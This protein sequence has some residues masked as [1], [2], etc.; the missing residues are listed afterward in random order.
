MP[1]ND[2]KSRRE[3][4]IK[5]RSSSPKKSKSSVDAQKSSKDKVVEGSRSTTP[6]KKDKDRDELSS[7][8]KSAKKDKERD[9]ED[10]EL[11]GGDKKSARRKEA[12]AAAALDKKKKSKKGE[13]GLGDSDSGVEMSSSK[14]DKSAKKSSDLDKRQENGKDR[15]RTKGK[16]E[17]S[18]TKSLKKAEALSAKVESGKKSSSRADLLSSTSNR[19]RSNSSSS[20]RGQKSG[21]PVRHLSFGQIYGKGDEDEVGP[22]ESPLR[23]SVLPRESS[24]RERMASLGEALGSCTKCL[25]L[26][27]GTGLTAW[28]IRR[29]FV[30]FRILVCIAYFVLG[31][32]YYHAKE[33]W[34]KTEAV[35]FITVATTTVGYGDFHPTTDTTRLFTTIYVV[36]GLVVVLAAANDVI[37]YFVVKKFQSKVLSAIDWIVRT[38]YVKCLKK[39]VKGSSL[40]SKAWFK[41]V[42]SLSCVVGLVFFG[43]TFFSSNED[44]TIIQALYWTVITML[45][46]GFGDMDVEKDSTRVFSTWFIWLCV[47][48]YVMAITNIFDTFEELKSEALRLEILKQHA[49][50]IVDVLDEE[51]RKR[52]DT[53]DKSILSTGSG[54]IQLLSLIKDGVTGADERGESTG[55]QRRASIR[56]LRKS[57]V[58]TRGRSASG[59]VLDASSDLYPT[60]D[61][62]SAARPMTEAELQAARAEHEN[63][64]MTRSSSISTMISKDQVL[65][66]A[67]EDRFVLEMLQKMNKAKY[68]RE[69]EPLIV[70]FHKLEKLRMV[71]GNRADMEKEL[72]EEHSGGGGLMNLASTIIGTK[73][74][75]VRRRASNFQNFKLN[76]DGVTIPAPPSNGSVRRPPPPPSP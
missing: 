15:G 22:S 31:V 70:H 3:S 39:E 9:R 25:I 33:G 1:D 51:G 30:L 50:D 57:G 68:E 10:T 32:E 20:A 7:S 52:K 5:E 8:K 55:E 75:V 12:E 54:A 60:V 61:P 49:I 74:A 53:A 56:L 43:T 35:Y 4:S 64:N 14:N 63:A 72:F 40:E 36:V 65:E 66:K 19:D 41:L 11:D 46:I 37:Q 69:V 45:T 27:C 34:T 13:Y 42:F 76:L 71:T 44:W 67:R 26:W 21:Q 59:T 6:V 17:E 23:A 16:D 24:G 18:D 29:R 28:L 62:A 48:I 2:K 47:I 73:K 58:L 38:Y